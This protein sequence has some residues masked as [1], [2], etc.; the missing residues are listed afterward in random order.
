MILAL[1]TETTGLDRNARPFAVAIYMED[2]RNRFWQTEVCLETRRPLWNPKDIEE[3]RDFLSE[4]STVVMH[5]RKF[6]L[7]MLGYIGLESKELWDKTEDTLP[8][9]HL[10]DSYGSHGLK[11]LGKDWLGISKDD[12][13][14]LKKEVRL[15]RREAK[16]EGL[17][18]GEKVEYD[19]FLPRYFNKDH[20]SLME[21]CI[22]DVKRTLKLYEMFYPV[23]AASERLLKLYQREK[24]IQ[25]ISQKMEDKGVLLNIDKVHKRIQEHKDISALAEASCKISEENDG[26]NIRSHKQM[27]GVI[28]EKYKTSVRVYTTSGLPSTDKEALDIIRE[29]EP[30]YTFVQYVKKY[31]NS[32][33]AIQFLENYLARIDKENVLHPNFNPTGTRTTRFSSS[34]PN[35]QNVAKRSAIPLRDIFIPRS[36]MVWLCIDYDQLELRILA[37]LAEIKKLQTAFV[38]GI[39]IHQQLADEIQVSRDAAKTVHY[40]AVYGAGHNKLD[41]MTGVLGIKTKMEKA[42]PEWVKFARER[43]QYSL[44]KNRTFTRGGYPLVVPGDKA[45]TATNYVIQGTA[46]DILKEAMLNIDREGF[47]KYL[48]LTIH[49]ELVFEIPEKLIWLKDTLK[50]CMVKAGTKFGIHTPVDATLCKDHWGE[51][52]KI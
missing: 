22:N 51:G 35:L 49:D 48:V 32:M 43:E 12:E 16:K 10:V 3:I 34:D 2:Y 5:N 47:L 25:W 17:L 38:E 15:A 18:V 4:A 52:E 42:Y 24:Q 21:Y 28:Y 27:K 13:E 14:S 39:D 46:G 45:Y 6:D 36:G 29:G 1:D 19:Y 11:D 31:K 20:V 8:L 23:I 9:S 40:A 37:K 41:G 50:N 26:L 44:D 33:K 30:A 7:R